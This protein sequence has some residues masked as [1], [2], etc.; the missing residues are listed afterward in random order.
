MR[1]AVGDV[2]IPLLVDREPILGGDETILAY[3]DDR[4]DDATDAERHR[5]QARE[6]VREF[7]EVAV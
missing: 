6:E 3:L 7:E 5:T 1:R 4:F 2:S